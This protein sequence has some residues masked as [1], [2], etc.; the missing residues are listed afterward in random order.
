VVDATGVGLS[1]V[2]PGTAGVAVVGWFAAGVAVVG[3]FAAGVA[4]HGWFAAGVAAA[5]GCVPAGRAAAGRYRFD[6]DTVRQPGR[7]DS[8]VA[9]ITP[10]RSAGG[11]GIA[12]RCGITVRHVRAGLAAGEPAVR[13]ADQFPACG[14]GRARPPPA[15]HRPRRWRR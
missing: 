15:S 3:W 11:P 2:R 14:G 7:R 9:G 8:I 10:A 5:L 12:G 13:R 4:A 1:A 6:A